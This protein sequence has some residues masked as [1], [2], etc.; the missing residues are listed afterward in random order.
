MIKERAAAMTQQPATIITQCWQDEVT[1]EVHDVRDEVTH[2]VRY[3]QEPEMDK[4]LLSTATQGI[5]YKK[6]I[7]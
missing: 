3:R 7:N 2:S 5:L 1:L 4:S 6:V